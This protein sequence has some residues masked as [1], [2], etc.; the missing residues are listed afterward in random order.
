MGGQFTRIDVTANPTKYGGVTISSPSLVVRSVTT[1]DAG[2][3]RCVAVNIA[4][5]GQDE[6]TLEIQGSK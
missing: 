6:T 2:Q 4:G 5:T 1:G 3:Y